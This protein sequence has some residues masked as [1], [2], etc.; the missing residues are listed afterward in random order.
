[1]QPSVKALKLLAWKKSILFVQK[2]PFVFDHV[3]ELLLESSTHKKHDRIPLVLPYN[4]TTPKISN[5]INKQWSLLTINPNLAKLLELKPILSFKR[6][7]NLKN[8]IGGNTLIDGKLKKTYK[9]VTKGQYKPC[10]SRISALCCKQVKTTSSFSN[11][12]NKKIFNI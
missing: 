7:K 3:P 12:V 5:I 8:L 4:R 1:M 10:Y 6:S 2:R 11:Y 9:P